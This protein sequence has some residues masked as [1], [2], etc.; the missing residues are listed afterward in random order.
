MDSISSRLLFEACRIRG[1]SRVLELY[2]EEKQESIKTAINRF[3]V[4]NESKLDLAL[5]SRIRFQIDA[6]MPIPSVLADRD[7]VMQ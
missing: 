2:P 5:W 6:L 4:I 1:R 3:P 7:E